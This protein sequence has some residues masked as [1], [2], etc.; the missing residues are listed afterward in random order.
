MAVVLLDRADGRGR[1]KR[2]SR[3]RG[4]DAAGQRGS[5]RAG[6]G[7]GN[8]PRLT[9]MNE[10]MLHQASDRANRII[11]TGREVSKEWPE[12]NAAEW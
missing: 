5:P 8:L 4:F 3:R 11:V 6:G 1:A 12:C 9:R 7:S 2:A 10:E